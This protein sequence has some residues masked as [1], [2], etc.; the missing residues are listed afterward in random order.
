MFAY[1]GSSSESWDGKDSF[2]LLSS[3]CM[4]G[5]SSCYMFLFKQNKKYLKT[6]TQQTGYLLCAK[7]VTSQL[8]VAA[9]LFPVSLVAVLPTL[10]TS[11]IVGMDT[12][13]SDHGLF[14]FAGSRDS[15]HW[16]LTLIGLSCCKQVF[17]MHSLRYLHPV[18][19]A[20]A[21]CLDAVIATYLSRYLFSVDADAPLHL[22]WAI[23]GSLF[24]LV[25]GSIACY[26]SVHKRSIVE[27]EVSKLK[28]RRYERHILTASNLKKSQIP[29]TEHLYSTECNS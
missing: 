3:V 18:V 28:R 21:K 19:L 13:T 23:P 1:P 12:S 26:V 17:Y 5:T 22:K 6:H 10:I 29:Y 14:G 27:L 8:P 15:F 11:A 16:W 25:G 7:N 9:V 24:V 2:A 20:S 4:S